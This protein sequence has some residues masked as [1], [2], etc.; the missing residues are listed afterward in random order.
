MSPESSNFLTH[1]CLAWSGSLPEDLNR[2]MHP[3]KNPDVGPFTGGSSFMKD[4][5]RMTDCAMV[6]LTQVVSLGTGT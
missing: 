5:V 2:E 3:W 1:S 6:D 4:G